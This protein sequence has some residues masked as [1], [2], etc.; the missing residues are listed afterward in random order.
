MQLDEVSG[1]VRTGAPIDD[2]EDYLSDSWAGVIPLQLI[3]LP[4][5]PDPK[6]REGIEMPDFVKRFRYGF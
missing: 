6:L 3:Q 5:V 4:A 2:E 1:K